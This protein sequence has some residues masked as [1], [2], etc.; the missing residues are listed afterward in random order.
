LDVDKLFLGRGRDTERRTLVAQLRREE[1]LEGRRLL[2][3]TYEDDIAPG[4]ESAYKRVCEF[5]NSEYHPVTTRWDRTNPHQLSDILT[6]F[7]QVEEAL[8]GTPFEWMLHT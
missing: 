6:N 4:P 7:S 2:Y 3:L 8:I 5:T 1:E